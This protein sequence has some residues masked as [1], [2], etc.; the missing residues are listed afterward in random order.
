[1]WAQFL[2]ELD[3]TFTSVPPVVAA[4]RLVA[5]LALG[6]VLGLEREMHAKPAGLRTHMLVSMAA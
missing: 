4:A 6:A 3:G 2:N 5:A 1:M